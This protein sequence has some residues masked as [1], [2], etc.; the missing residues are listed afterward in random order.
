MVELKSKRESLR[1]IT[2]EEL[3]GSIALTS[4]ETNVDS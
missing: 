4:M 1:N 3:D 2:E